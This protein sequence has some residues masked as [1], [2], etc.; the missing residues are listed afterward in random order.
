MW[1][2]FNEMK[3]IGWVNGKLP[4]MIAVQATGC[5]P[6]VRAYEDGAE[7]AELWEGAHTVAAGIRVPVAIGDF[8]ILRAI[9]ESNG[10][11]TAVDDKKILEARNEVAQQEGILLCPEGAA[12]YAAYKKELSSGRISPSESAILFNCA[13]GL[14]YELPRMSRF[15]DC[16]QQVIDYSK[17]SD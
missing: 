13:S 12:T 10:F 11:A 8:L 3:E 1:K 14:K 9:R 2:A 15:L 17:L 16:T 7:H 4:R 6:I 5:A